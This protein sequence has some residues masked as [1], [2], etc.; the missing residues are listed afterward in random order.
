MEIPVE[1]EGGTVPADSGNSSESDTVCM[2]TRWF[3][4]NLSQFAFLCAD[5]GLR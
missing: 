4:Q 1:A 3:Q 5:F 2:Q